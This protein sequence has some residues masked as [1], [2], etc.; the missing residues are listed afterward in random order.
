MAS[1]V[2]ITLSDEAGRRIERAAEEEGMPVATLLARVV[3]GWVGTMPAPAPVHEGTP[4]HAVRGSLEGGWPLSARR[5][6]Q[7]RRRASRGL[8]GDV[9]TSGGSSG[10]GGVR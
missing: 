4:F 2:T 1:R 3:E 7:A 9:G 5:D 8:S 6:R 10:E